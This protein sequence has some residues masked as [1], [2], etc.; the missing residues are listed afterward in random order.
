VQLGEPV[1]L[2]GVIAIGRHDQRARLAKPGAET[3]RRG[4]LG[5]EVG[6]ALGR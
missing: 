3:G 4:Q 6:P 5:G 1:E 2:L